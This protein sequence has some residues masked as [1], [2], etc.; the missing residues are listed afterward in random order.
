MKKLLTTMFIAASTLPALALDLNLTT[1]AEGLRVLTAKEAPEDFG[2]GLP[3]GPSSVQFAGQTLWAVDSLNGRFVEYDLTGKELRA[4][5]VDNADKLIIADFAF[6]KDAEGKNIAIWAVGSEEAQ[7]LKID[8]EGKILAS[9]STGLSFPARIELLPGGRLAILDQEPPKIATFDATG[10]KLH[11][12][13]CL[14]KGFVAE[15]DG[16][17]LF[18]GRKDDK[19]VLSRLG[20]NPAKP[21]TELKV[22]DVSCDSEPSLLMFRNNDEVFFSFH[23]L[24]EKTGA[25]AFNITRTSL[26]GNFAGSRTVE[27]PAA[28]INRPLLDDGKSLFMVQFSDMN[29]AYLLKINEFE[30]FEEASEG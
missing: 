19:V 7:V 27:F 26:A 30:M 4:V 29:G 24:D 1:N 28:F 18:L 22:L 17:I 23:S 2:R 10:K 5:K 16:N 13:P 8:L 25:Y 20:D 11:E 12:Q 14:G 3:M 21:V 6:E 15:A 9:F